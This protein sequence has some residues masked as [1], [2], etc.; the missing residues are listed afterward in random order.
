MG[1][2][3]FDYRLTDREVMFTSFETFQQPLNAYVNAPLDRNR[4]TVGIQVSLSSETDRRMNHSN[5]DAQ[6][7]A[8]TDHQ[9]RRPTAQ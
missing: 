5:E 1:R 4:F 7:V 3:R 2:F 6:Y 8:L 9:R